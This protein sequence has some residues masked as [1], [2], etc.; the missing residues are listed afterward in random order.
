MAPRVTGTSEGAVVVIDASYGGGYATGG[1][2]C[3]VNQG[4]PNTYPG[5]RQNRR[6]G[7]RGPGGHRRHARTSHCRP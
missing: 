1:F 6:A 3:Q 2:V 5:Q 4:C 7:R